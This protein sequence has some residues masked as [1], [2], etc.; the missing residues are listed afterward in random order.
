MKEENIN[1]YLK[2][3][4]KQKKNRLEAEK[5]VKEWL[6]YR[7]EH[8]EAILARRKQLYKYFYED[9]SPVSFHIPPGSA[10]LE[11]DVPVKTEEVKE[12]ISSLLH[13]ADVDHKGDTT[14][15]F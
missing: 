4:E 13:D 12:I 14:G 6:K 15:I 10:L 2:E 7:E 9:A 8:R 11:S 1:D 5:R 3:Q